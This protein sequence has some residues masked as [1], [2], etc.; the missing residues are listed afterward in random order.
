MSGFWIGPGRI[1]FE[2]GTSEAL[3]CKAYYT[4]PHQANRLSIVLR[5]ASRSNKIE[6][7]AKLV[8][9]DRI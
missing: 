2:A 1:E 8:A 5:C 3:L 7:R 6:L 4:T 9:E